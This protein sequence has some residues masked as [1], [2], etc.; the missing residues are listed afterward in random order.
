VSRLGTGQR[1]QD[2]RARSGSVF[3]LLRLCSGCPL[4]AARP[5]GLTN[6]QVTR[7]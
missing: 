3:P 2:L 5:V 4:V 1:W 7:T 6:T